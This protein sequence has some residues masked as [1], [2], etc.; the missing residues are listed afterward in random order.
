MVTINFDFT[1]FKETVSG[2]SPSNFRYQSEI[3]SPQFVWVNGVTEVDSLD[4]V[5][6]DRGPLQA[7]GYGVVLYIKDQGSRIEK[8]I[9]DPS[10]GKKVHLAYCRTLHDMEQKGRFDRYHLK[11]EPDGMFPVSGSLYRSAMI[12]QEVSLSVCK[13][14]L[15]QLN[16]N[17]YRQL[18]WAGG[19]R[20]KAT[21]DF[22][23]GAFFENY[24]SF[25]PK[26]PIRNEQSPTGYTS[27]WQEI[28]KRV[29]SEVRNCCQECKVDLSSA[30]DLLHTHHVNGVK[31]DN[32]S[33]NLRVL[34]AD[35][36][37][38]QPNHEHVHLNGTECRFIH[39]ARKTQDRHPSR[40]PNLVD[41]AWL[42]PLRQFQ[43]RYGSAFEQYFDL[44]DGQNSVICNLTIAFVAEKVGLLDQYSDRDKERALA[45]GWKLFTHDEA[46]A[47]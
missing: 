21:R 2:L 39:E 6:K 24:S 1:K 40:E 5:V 7:D 46:M 17:G 13:N 41:P 14:C 19:G 10:K 18:G 20:D 12:E 3:D 35:C 37:R 32:S 34:C 29:R 16:Y 33:G 30:P 4:L 15:K 11:R 23:Y 22:D 31:T 43:R 27:D 42:Q 36:H 9:L 45:V 38:H 8:V 44:D 28:S 47:T 25:F 26:L